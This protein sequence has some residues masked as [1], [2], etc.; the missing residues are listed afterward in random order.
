MATDDEEF[1]LAPVFNFGV[2]I[3][4]ILLVGP[5]ERELIIHG[6][7][8]TGSAFFK[9]AL[10]KEW[11]E[12]QTRVIKLPE[13]TPEIMSHYIQHIYSGK[14]Q[15][16]QYTEKCP[17][18]KKSAGY[19]LLAKLYVLGERLLDSTFRNAIICEILRIRELKSNVAPYVKWNPTTIPTNIIYQGAPER[20]PARRLIIDVNLIHGNKQWHTSDADQRFL[21]D[22]TVGLFNMVMPNTVEQVRGRGLKAEDYFV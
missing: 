6:H 5:E 22:L 3:V 13:E 14:F 18:G 21:F 17:G 10:K 4:V 11:V 1:V 2:E 19:E 12:G 8:F 7:R 15:T 20:S 9:A 16:H